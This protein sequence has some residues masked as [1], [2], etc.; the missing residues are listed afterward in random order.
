MKSVLKNKWNEFLEN[1]SSKREPVSDTNWF[2]KAATACEDV[3]DAV[4]REDKGVSSKVAK[5][6]AGKL[7]VAGT[8]VSIFSIASLL[9]TASTGLL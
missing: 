6:I 3:S 2:A 5:G 1:Y 4:L 7:R 9:G 8:S